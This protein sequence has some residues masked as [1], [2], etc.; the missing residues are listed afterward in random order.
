MYSRGSGEADLPRWRLA[1]GD[2][3]GDL[4]DIVVLGLRPFGL[5]DYVWNENRRKSRDEVCGQWAD[6]DGIKMEAS[7]LTSPPGR[8]ESSSLADL[9]GQLL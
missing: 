4:S 6:D 1:G 7:C 3:S 5:Q 8:V 2:R 9:L